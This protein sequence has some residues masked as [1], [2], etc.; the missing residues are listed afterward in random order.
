MF[1]KVCLLQKNMVV[2]RKIKMLKNIILSL[3]FIV[4]IFWT[5]IS[6]VN[7]EEQPTIE[8]LEAKIK[9]L[10]N[11]LLQVLNAIK[12]WE[13]WENKIWNK[14]KIRKAEFELASNSDW[15]I[16][17]TPLSDI[18]PSL[19]EYSYIIS[20]NW[21]WS[22]FSSGTTFNN[23]YNTDNAWKYLVIKI[24]DLTD[25]ITY[26]THRLWE[27]QTDY[28]NIRSNWIFDDAFE[29]G[30]K[31]WGLE[32]PI[33]E[34][35][36]VRNHFKCKLNSSGCT[37]PQN[38]A[39][40]YQLRSLNS[41]GSWKVITITWI[42]WELSWIWS[43]DF[44]AIDYCNW[45]LTWWNSCLIKI[46]KNDPNLKHEEFYR[47]SFILNIKYDDEVILTP[48]STVTWRVKWVVSN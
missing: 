18:A 26:T 45:K 7:A 36:E 35:T 28:E 22:A 29:L 20:P 41:N 10:E 47:Y 13:F 40:T 23:L 5:N 15:D 12:S 3:W 19:N 39:S 31:D 34:I 6:F 25:Q 46:F 37:I 30:K 42:Y 24:K 44:S 2:Y 27:S 16:I 9:K 21:T 4:I 38:L 32:K 8:N 48:S 1:I 17:I 33:I 11:T 43:Q 14:T